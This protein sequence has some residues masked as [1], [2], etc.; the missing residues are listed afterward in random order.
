MKQSLL[1]L[2]A[3]AL[4]SL[5]AGCTTTKI[6]SEDIDVLKI[7]R[8]EIA[9]LHSSLPPNSKEKYEAA[10][11]LADNVDFSFTRSVQTLDEIFS[12][13]DARV[14][15][16][17]AADQMLMFYYQYRDHSIRFCFYRYGDTITKVEIIEK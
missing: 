17:N 8:P 1:L 9:V 14:D 4:L 2:V 11:V 13:V 5:I 6:P 10:K 16:P 12:A 3:A 7:Y 15:V